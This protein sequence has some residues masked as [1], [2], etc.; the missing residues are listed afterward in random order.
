MFIFTIYNHCHIQTEFLSW[1]RLI[2]YTN[3]KTNDLWE[4]RH[5]SEERFM[6]DSAVCNCKLSNFR[7]CNSRLRSLQ[8]LR[9]GL[10]VFCHLLTHWMLSSGSGCFQSEWPSHNQ[11]ETEGDEEST[12]E[13]GETAGKA[14]ERGQ[15]QRTAAS[16]HWLCVLMMLFTLFLHTLHLSD[17][18][19]P[20]YQ[21]IQSV[22]G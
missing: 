15:T 3:V 1:S 12:R 2:C 14:W 7:K 21:W 6:N 18:Y 10:I 5:V 22:T 16:Q 20:F 11:E 8:H 17:T 19:E 9:C 13:D 4:W